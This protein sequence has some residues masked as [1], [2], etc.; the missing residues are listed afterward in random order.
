[1]DPVPGVPPA[2]EP[3]GVPVMG[4]YPVPGP[5][6]PRTADIAEPVRATWRAELAG[7][8][9]RSPLIH[10][11]DGP[12]TRIELSTTHPG[13]LARFITGAT[14]L[15]SQLIRDDMALRAAR[16]A[17]TAGA[18]VLV[19]VPRRGYVP[20]LACAR[21]R[22]VARCR[23][24]TG[25]LSLPDRDAAGAVC[26]WCARTEPALRCGRCGAEAVRAVVVGA[27]RTAEELGRAFPGV[28]V[29][30]SG[31]LVAKVTKVV[32]DGE[33]EVEIAE[34]VKA[35]LVRG[36]ISEVRSKSEPVKTEAPKS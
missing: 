16:A 34:G 36:M 32:D 18:P 27:R 13:G 26:R 8:G 6:D 24:C 1:V 11:D 25:P 28:T 30:T 20:A 15:L 14:T 31:G 12:T 22:T 3:A 17:L 21:C 29:V 2:A 35:R 7:V 4:P 33:I 9:G 23:H 5:E 10:F 19:Q